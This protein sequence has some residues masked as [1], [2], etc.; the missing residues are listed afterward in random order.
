MLT[1][2][3]LLI[4]SLAA[5]GATAGPL[6]I[7]LPFARAAAPGGA[8]IRIEIDPE[9][10]YNVQSISLIV[11]NVLGGYLL[12]R[13]VYLDETGEPKPWLADA[14]QT[15]DDGKMVTFKLKPGKIFH[16]GTPFNAEAVKFLFDTI[17]DPNSAS[18]SK[19]IIGPLEKADAVDDMTVSFTFSKPFAPFLGLLGQ[20]FFGFNSP[21]AVKAAGSAYARHPV[22]TGPFMFKSWTPGTEVVVVRNPNFKQFRP[23]AANQGLPYLES[24]TLRVMT[25]EGVVASALQTGELD[26]ASLTA[27]A[28]KPFDG[29][30]DDYRTLLAPAARRRTPCMCVNPDKLMLTASGNAPGAGRIAEIYEELGGDVTWVGKPF[31]EIYR[32]ASELSQVQNPRDVLC[33]GDSVEHDIA[34]ANWFGAF[35]ALVRT[36]ILAGLSERELA[37]EIGKT[38]ASALNVGQRERTADGAAAVHQIIHHLRGGSLIGRG[39]IRDGRIGRDAKRQ[40]R[41]DQAPRFWAC[42]SLHIAGQMPKVMRVPVVVVSTLPG[43]C[44]CASWVKLSPE[45]CMGIT[46]SGLSLLIS[47]TTCVR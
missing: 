32:A 8:N 47:A 22:G 16:D 42:T 17:L 14:W 39:V 35:A 4:R 6:T 19:G 10:L 5:A 31:P 38:A 33:V 13:L 37:A 2:R 41:G 1:R 29:D 40:Q 18:P 23:D 15:S 30:L 24:I 46:T 27:D 20:S 44:R 28:V 7:A 34:G 43:I 36:G 25:E 9:G 21:T 12:E 26:V 3:R 11:S 45:Q